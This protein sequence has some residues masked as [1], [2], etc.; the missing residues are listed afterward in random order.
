MMCRGCGWIYG[1]NNGAGRHKPMPKWF[2][3]GGS[4]SSI[5]L[6]VMMNVLHDGSRHD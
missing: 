1:V 6:S 3:V 4:S 5:I 2:G